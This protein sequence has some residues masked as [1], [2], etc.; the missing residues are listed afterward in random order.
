[1]FNFLDDLVVY[2]RSAEEHVAHVLEVLGRLQSAG[3]TLNQDKVTFG[4]SEIKYLDTYFRP[5]GLGCSRIG[6]RPLR[7]IHV[8]RT[9]GL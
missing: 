7:T 2:S 5:V 1:M 3:F 9:C 6:W 8:R 4:A